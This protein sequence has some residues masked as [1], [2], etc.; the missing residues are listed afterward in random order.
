MIRI[1]GNN[2]HYEGTETQYPPEYGHSVLL[3]ITASA[4]SP[5]EEKK[6]RM[7]SQKKK[8]NCDIPVQ[9]ELEPTTGTVRPRWTVRTLSGST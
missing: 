2:R 7:L 3:S 1:K 4:L 5:V 9:N 8:L 6:H